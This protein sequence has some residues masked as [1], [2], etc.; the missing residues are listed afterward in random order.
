MIGGSGQLWLLPDMLRK[1][2]PGKYKPAENPEWDVAHGAAIVEQNPGNFTL[3]ETLGL[4]FRRL[5]DLVHPHFTFFVPGESVWLRYVT[6]VSILRR[7]G[8][9][10]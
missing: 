2:F 6:G 7:S 9:Y 5:F 4:R 1:E 8:G 3:A 10:L